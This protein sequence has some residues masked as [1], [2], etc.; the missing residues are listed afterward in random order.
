M[1]NYKLTKKT[2][3]SRLKEMKSQKCVLRH[4]VFSVNGNQ[5]NGEWLNN[6][7]HGKGIQV[8]K[9]A[10]AIYDGEWK[11]GK[12]NGYGTYS[13]LLLKSKEYVRKYAGEWKNGKKHGY[14]VYFYNNSAVYDG[15][16][17]EDQRSGKGTMHYENGDIYVGEWQMDKSHGQG[18]LF[19]NGKLYEGTWEDGKMNGDGKLYYSE[20]GLL[21]EGFWV[22]GEAKCGT[23]MD[24][25]RDKA[26]APPKYP[27]PKLHL[28]DV[29]SVLREAKSACL[30][31]CCQQSSRG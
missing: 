25:R 2:S 22:D 12:R 28:K 31:H 13:V 23:M 8:W 10:G 14:G 18:H 30:D 5:Y 6:K 24:F 15:E 4:T 29:E 11:F 26:P 3:V 1:P 16:W 7:K 19:S 9:Q 27:F 17:S 21:Y 20:K